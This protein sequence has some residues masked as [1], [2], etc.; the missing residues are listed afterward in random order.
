MQQTG[1]VVVQGAEGAFRDQT[2]GHHRLVGDDEQAK[3]GPGEAGEG[4]GDAGEDPNI[5]ARTRKSRSS[6]RTP[7]RSRKTARFTA[8]PPRG[9]GRGRG[10]GRRCVGERWGKPD[11]HRGA[12]GMS[13]G[14]GSA[15][16]GAVCR[17]A[18]CPRRR[19]SGRRWRSGHRARWRRW[20]CRTGR[21]WVCRRGVGRWRDAM[22]FGG[23][24]E[25]LVGI[26]PR[27]ARSGLGEVVADRASGDD[28]DLLGDPGVGGGDD[29]SPADAATPP[30]RPGVKWEQ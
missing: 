10:A 12:R 22:E 18:R 19:R 2:P 20:R 21:S 13:V 25:H 26:G 24:G 17:C 28:A 15:G 6:M 7:S 5:L 9:R 4:L 29:S 16:R 14:Q 27:E 23:A 11:E 30:S 3:A 1:E 8:S